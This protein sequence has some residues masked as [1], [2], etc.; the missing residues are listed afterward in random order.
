MLKHIDDSGRV[1]FTNAMLPLQDF[2][3]LVETHLSRISHT[4][5]LE[6]AGKQLAA[7]DFPKV[8]LEGFILRVCTWGGYAGIAG[9]VFNQ[10]DPRHI[11]HQFI[12]AASFLNGT[13]TDIQGALES[14][15]QIRQLGTPSFASK[16][17][18]FLRPDICPV[19]DS[20]NVTLGYSFNPKGYRQ[21]AQDCARIAHALE[22]HAIENPIKRPHR[23]WFVGDIDMA[24]FAHL[25]KW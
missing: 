25:N 9:R 8:E 24:I 2:P 5:Q 6:T 18:R 10:N 7:S 22:V 4:I 23:T 16:H 3:H 20:K 12:Q 21:F 13:S 17:L 14:L 1:V 19:L 15:N 11:R